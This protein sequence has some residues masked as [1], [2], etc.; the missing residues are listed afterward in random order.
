LGQR[1]VQAVEVGYHL[2]DAGDRE[3]PQHSGARHRQQ[4]RT[5]RGQGPLMRIHHDTKPG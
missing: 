3:N 2:I 1:L 4:H 5:T